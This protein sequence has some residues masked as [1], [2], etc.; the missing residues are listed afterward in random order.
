M[1]VY[2]GYAVAHLVETLP[3]RPEGHGFGSRIPTASLGFFLLTKSF[4]PHCDSGI[5]SASNINEHHGF[6]VAIKA[7]GA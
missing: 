4:W 5:D 6:L 3:Y 7:A 1:Y 2:W